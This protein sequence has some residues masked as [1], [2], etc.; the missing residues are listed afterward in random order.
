M[1]LHFKNILNKVGDHRVIVRIP[2]I[3]TF[4]ADFESLSAI[5]SFL[6]EN[7][8]NGEVHLM[9]YHELGK[10]KYMRINREPIAIPTL[11]KADLEQFKQFGVL[12]GR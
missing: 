7:S 3:P 9:P 12:Y 6:Q 4:N 1:Q 2:L 10:G 8:F 5:R 11:E